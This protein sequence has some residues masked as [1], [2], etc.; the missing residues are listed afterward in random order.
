MNFPNNFGIKK[1][2]DNLWLNKNN[3]IKLNDLNSLKTLGL[4]IQ[5]I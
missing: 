4:W 5:F 2:Y 3:I 1:Q